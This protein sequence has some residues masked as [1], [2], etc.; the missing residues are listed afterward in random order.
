[1]LRDV[2]QQSMSRHASASEDAD[3]PHGHGHS[4]DDGTTWQGTYCDIPEHALEFY[5]DEESQTLAQAKLPDQ[6]EL[7][8]A[9]AQVRR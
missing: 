1:M 3:T 4:S 8:Q 2:V 5:S 7:I 9:T 6:H